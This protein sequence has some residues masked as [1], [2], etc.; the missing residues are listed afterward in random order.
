MKIK[1]IFSIAL[2]TAILASCGGGS[3]T[4]GE[5]KEAYDI[6]GVTL[7]MNEVKGGTFAMGTLKDRRLVKSLE[8]AS[9][10]SGARQVIMDGIAISSEPVSQKLW[11]AVM[12]DNPSSTQSDDLPVDRISY[13]DAQKFVKKLSKKIGVELMV[14]TEAMW[15]YALKNDAIKQESGLREWTSDCD[16]DWKSTL[17]TNP[18]SESNGKLMIIRTDATREAVAGFTKMPKVGFRV[19][20][21]TGKECDPELISV[22]TGDKPAQREHVCK[23]E[24]IDV[25]GVNFEMVAV[26]GGNFT[27]GATPEQAKYADENEKPATL[28]NVEDFEIGKT[29]V[30]VAQWCSVMDYLPAGNSRDEAQKPV[31]NV[32]WYMAQEFVAKL[33][34]VTGRKFRLPTEAEWEYAARGG[35]KSRGYIFSGSNSSVDVGLCGTNNPSLKVG[36]VKMYKANELGIYDMTGN[37]W[38][39]CQDSF[40]KYG[41]AP[42]VS[43]TK[44]MRSGSAASKSTY[45]RVSNRSKMPAS[46]VK[47]TF[48][49]RLAI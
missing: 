35:D 2:A 8:G 46:N 18:S 6:D 24:S 14:P 11:V 5:I 19:A 47:G 27:M 4:S 16:E 15:E 29:E 48:G 26:K 34:E 3:K 32:S 33:N 40:G 22:L 21:Y 41:E 13:D 38:E 39:W 45:C 36:K 44:V 23:S 28:T 37:A 9:A 25:N 20:A 1:N 43:E 49:V 12:G 10:V 42:V 17:A 30:T 31:I 7:K